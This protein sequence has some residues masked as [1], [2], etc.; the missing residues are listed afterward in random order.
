MI[1]ISYLLLLCL[2]VGR[3]VHSA[4]IARLG[5]NR[6]RHDTQC[7]RKQAL[8]SRP[9]AASQGV[10]HDLE[11]RRLDKAAAGYSDF[12]TLVD[13]HRRHFG[14]DPIGQPAEAL[15]FPC[16][17]GP[18]SRNFDWERSR[19]SP[20]MLPV[21]LGHRF[22]LA[23]SGSRPDLIGFGQSGKLGGV[24]DKQIQLWLL[25]GSAAKLV[26]G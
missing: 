19:G 6:S 12:S 4:H 22:R 11:Y 17:P 9:I 5:S 10:G 16:G 25:S 23:R 13:P 8:T 24:R 7:R 3:L 2:V 1:S 14:Q 20:S 15:L 26:H 21:R 18:P